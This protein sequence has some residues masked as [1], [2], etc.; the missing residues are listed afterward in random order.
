MRTTAVELRRR[1]VAFADLS[2]VFVS[3]RR[4]IYYDVCHL[5]QVGNE[6]LAEHVAREYLTAMYSGG[7]GG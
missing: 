5:N 4:T 1:G 7:G 3:E 2:R 6:L